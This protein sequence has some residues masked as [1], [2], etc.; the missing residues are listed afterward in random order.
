MS[1]IKYFDKPTQVVF[2]DT[3]WWRPLG[4]VVSHT[5][6]RLFAVVVVE[7]KKS[8]RFM[9]S[10][11]PTVGCPIREYDEWCID[12]AIIGG[13]LARFSWRRN[14]EEEEYS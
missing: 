6:M 2:W 7:L 11:P 14:E 1:E 5:E 12:D 10:H 13:E 4:L 9:S 3:R 8:L